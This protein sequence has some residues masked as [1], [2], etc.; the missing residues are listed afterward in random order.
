MLLRCPYNLFIHFL[1]GNPLWGCFVRAFLE[2][3]FLK[4]VG[5]YHI[6]D[7]SIGGS[8]IRRHPMGGFPMGGYS[9]G[10]CSIGDYLIRDDPMRVYTLTALE[11]TL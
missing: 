3:R 6:G 5:G 10:G 4:S 1:S 7:Y 11:V 8:P 2:E 9:I